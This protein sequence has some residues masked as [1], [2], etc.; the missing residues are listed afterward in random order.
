MIIQIILVM[1]FSFCNGGNCMKMNEIMEKE[2]ELLINQTDIIIENTIKK[3]NFETISM[4]WKL[5]KMIF[6]YKKEQNSKYGD[7]VVESFSSELSLKY[8]RGFGLVNI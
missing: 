7:S 1:L 2:V 3:I 8:G 5:G 6:E 4:Y